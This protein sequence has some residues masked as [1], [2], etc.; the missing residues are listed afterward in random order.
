MRWRWSLIL[1]AAFALS[2]LEAQPKVALSFRITEKTSLGQVLSALARQT[3]AQLRMDD[4]TRTFVH[5]YTFPPNM[6]GLTVRGNN[7]GE[8][9]AFLFGAGWEGSPLKR[10]FRSQFPNR[11][12]ARTPMPV[13]IGNKKLWACNNRAFDWKWEKPKGGPAG[14]IITVRI[15]VQPDG[16]IV[17]REPIDLRPLQNDFSLDY[18]RDRIKDLTGIYFNIDPEW[19][20]NVNYK[21]LPEYRGQVLPADPQIPL[22]VRKMRAIFGDA[23]DRPHTLGQWLS[24][25]AEGLNEHSKAR[26]CLWKWT[27]SDSANPIYTLR[28]YVHTEND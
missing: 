23:L 17:R 21:L 22:F 11:M 4:E 18:L 24:I 19:H 7:V 27:C 1:V 6:I 2:V 25:F 26:G 14:G 20:Q 5:R 28:C 8:V 13:F 3:T 16:D 10:E 12:L 9:L 15:R